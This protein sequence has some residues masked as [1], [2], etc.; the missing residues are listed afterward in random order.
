MTGSVRSVCRM[1]AAFL[2]LTTCLVWSQSTST[3]TV[4]G[5]VTDPSAAVVQGAEVKLTDAATGKSKI[6]NTNDAGRY[7]FSNVPLGNYDITVS[8][9]GFAQTKV[10]QQTVSVGSTTTVNVAMTLGAATETVTV[11]ASGAQLQ[12]TNATVGTT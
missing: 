10:A 5:Q 8:K 12:T 1:L 6:A 9:A 2:F 3:G 4:A 11:E 7:V